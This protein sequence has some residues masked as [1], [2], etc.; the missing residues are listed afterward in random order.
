MKTNRGP[1]KHTLIVVTI[2]VITGAVLAAALY[3]LFA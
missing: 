2:A 3:Y 1:V